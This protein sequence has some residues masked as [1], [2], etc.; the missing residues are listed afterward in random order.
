[1]LHNDLLLSSFNDTFSGRLTRPFFLFRDR[2]EGSLGRGL[3]VDDS[4]KISINHL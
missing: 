3:G 1:M 4:S 2:L